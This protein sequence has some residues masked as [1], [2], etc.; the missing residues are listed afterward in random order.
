MERFVLMLHGFALF[1]RHLRTGILF[2]RQ[3]R[4]YQERCCCQKYHCH[5]SRTPFFAGLTFRAGFSTYALINATGVP[6]LRAYCK[7]SNMLLF[8]MVFAGF[9]FRGFFAFGSRPRFLPDL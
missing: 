3:C 8:A 6:A 7:F 5:E 2:V 4:Q 1:F 9:F